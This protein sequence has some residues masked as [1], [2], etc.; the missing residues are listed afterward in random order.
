MQTQREEVACNLC[1]SRRT[2]LWDEVR[3]A[4]LVRCLD[5]GLVY[6]NPRPALWVLMGSYEEEYSE[7]HEEPELLRQR[8]VM[9]RLELAEILRRR[10]GGRLL[11][12]GCGTGEFLSLLRDHFEVHGTDVS[13]HYIEQARSLYGLTHLSVGQLGEVGFDEGFFDVVQMRGVLQHVP[14]P[15]SQLREAFR[16]TKPGGMLIIS[17][18]PNIASPAARCFRG[19]FRLL[20]PDQMLYDFSPRTLQAL[21]A[22]AGFRVQGFTYPYMNT[23]YFRWH[24]PLQFVSL[25]AALRL[26]RALGQDVSAI[27]S[28][29]FFRSMMNCYAIK[30]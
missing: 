21:L 26:K 1:G 19:N 17:A 24:Q 18:T 20:A 4:R 22:K 13:R 6:T 2:V 30:P 12:V 15:L 27:K 23:P 3:G 7:A 9:Y 25:T 5:C 28:P 16:I 10:H 29:P 14:D 8:Q 11:D